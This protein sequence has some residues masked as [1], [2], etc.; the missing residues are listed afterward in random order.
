MPLRMRGN[1]R[2]LTLQREDDH[3]VAVSLQCGFVEMQGHGRDP[4]RRVPVRGD[5]AVLVLD[6]PTTEVDADALS[7][8]LDGPRVEVWSPITMAMDDSFE[9]LHLFLASQ[10][11]PYGVLNVNRE[12]TG[13]L[14]DPQDRFFCPTLLTGDSLAY[15]SIRQH[16]T[17]WQLGAHGFG[18]DATTL[19]HDLIDL[20]GAWRQRDRCGDRPEITVY[21]AG[22]EL[23]DTELLRL[24]VPRRHRLTV[25]TWPEVAR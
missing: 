23:A 17:A 6:D 9:G 11:R 20:V 4:V 21:P 5:D 25:I 18:P 16:G 2:C 1:T 22:T 14:L 10:P 13:G 3:L 7:A 8:A 19:V 12:A 15:L 24:L